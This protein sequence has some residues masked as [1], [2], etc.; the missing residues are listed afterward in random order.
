M[1]SKPFPATE[2]QLSS[3]TRGLSYSGRKT[4]GEEW[5]QDEKIRRK[6]L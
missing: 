6:P 1:R 5:V 3:N 2:L 4:Q